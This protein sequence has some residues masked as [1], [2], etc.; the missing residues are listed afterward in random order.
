MHGFIGSSFSGSS[1]RKVRLL[2]KLPIPSRVSFSQGLFMSYE[3]LVTS[4][5]LLGSVMNWETSEPDSS[6]GGNYCEISFTTFLNTL[7]KPLPIFRVAF[8]APLHSDCLCL[9]PLKNT[10]SY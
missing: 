3:N 1:T 7:C 5:K 2:I 10:L 4:E 8:N 9:I 6:K